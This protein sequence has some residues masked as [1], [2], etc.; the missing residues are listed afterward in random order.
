MQVI[1][2]A[3]DAAGEG[4]PPLFDPLGEG[5]D[6]RDLEASVQGGALT[7][8]AGGKS[9]VGGK[10]RNYIYNTHTDICTLV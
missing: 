3:A 10:V 9:S 4:P 6:V 8:A 1:R 2:Q 5:V 7:T